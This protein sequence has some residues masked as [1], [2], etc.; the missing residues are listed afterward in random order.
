MEIM[1]MI[2]EISGASMIDANAGCASDIK[3]TLRDIHPRIEYFHNENVIMA[4]SE[5]CITLRKILE[6][7]TY[8]GHKL[9]DAHFFCQF[10]RKH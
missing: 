5:M 7:Q 1:E 3:E 10:V 4:L 8:N 2:H 6:N 9:L